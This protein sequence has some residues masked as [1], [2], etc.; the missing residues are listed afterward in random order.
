MNKALIICGDFLPVRNGGTIR[1]E[2]LVKY[3][4]NFNWESIV[5]TKKP[6][7]KEKIDLSIKLE[8]CVIYR[9]NRFDLAFSF[10]VLK[11][12]INS[13]F[14]K[15]N[16]TKKTQSKNTEKTIIKRRIT[17]YFLLPDSDIFWAV[18]AFVKAIYIVLKVKPKVIF[19]TGPMH[20]AHIIGLLLKKVTRKKWIVEFRDPWTMNPF[21]AK[22][23]F[24]I[25]CQIDDYLEKIVL[26]NADIIN[27]T[28]IEYKNQFLNKYKF[29][30]ETKIVNIPNGFDPDD[31]KDKSS[32]INNKLTIVHSGNFYSER[33]SS[34]F[35][36]AIL[37]LVKEGVL[38]SDKITIKFVG[39]LDDIGKQIILNSEFPH[40]FNVTGQVSHRKS[41]DEICNADLLLLIPGPGLGTMP[42]KFY[43]YLAASKPIFCMSNEGPAKE[44]IVKYNLGSVSSDNDIE[45]IKTKL[46]ILITEILEG[47]FSPHNISGLL[48]KFN[49]ENIAEQM[50]KIFSC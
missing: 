22:K 11:K 18:G 23:P 37:E 2:K 5:L 15:Q 16:E 3:L 21:L 39:L 17:E 38:K 40:I 8:H 1:C 9:T 24:K 33:S 27:V 41:I 49:R 36:E 26:K 43:E 6:S 20:S 30:S 48:Q 44:L 4:P 10:V 13:L 31:F 47:K 45:E 35:I 12:K 46:Q 32:N 34:V 50:A 19:S 42:G 14:F 25:L 7:N 29:I 28:S